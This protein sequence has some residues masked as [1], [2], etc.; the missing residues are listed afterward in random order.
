[1]SS[2]DRLT[3]APFLAV[4]FVLWPVVAVLGA[5]GFTPALGIAAIPALVFSQPRHLRPYMAAFAA[6]MVWVVAS[7]AWSPTEG[8]IVS[9]TLAEGNFA[10]NAAGLRLF[11][12]ALA[13]VGVLMATMGIPPGTAPRT[14]RIILRAFGAHA[15]LLLIVVVFTDQILTL[16][17]PKASAAT[18]APQNILRNANAFVI[19]LPILASAIWF[20]ARKPALKWTAPAIIAASAVIFV[21][22]DLSSG[23]IGLVLGGIAIGVV[24]VFKRYGLRILFSGLGAYLLAAP[25]LLG[26]LASFTERF[27]IHLPASFQSRAWSWQ[28]VTGRI[29]EH[30]LFGNGLEASKTFRETY[31]DHPDWLARVVADGGVEQAW[32]VYPVVPGHPHNMPLQIWAETGLVG[33]LLFAGTLVLIGWRLPKPDMLA[34]RT[35]IAAA[36]LIGA[37]TSLA[38]FAYS[39]WNEAFWSTLALAVAALV[40]LSRRVR[41]SLG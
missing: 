15:V 16:L 36:G 17:N 11:L 35:R 37:A 6:L 32:A 20:G 5:Q 19:A 29:L 40:L 2:E 22:L 4:A 9:G 10:V 12:T 13:G 21:Y 28:V 31:G 41:G 25:I 14:T 18:E 38:S 3:Y 26:G 8:G 23:L 30:P 27:G 33:A 39:A 34:A 24:L 7:S 1:M